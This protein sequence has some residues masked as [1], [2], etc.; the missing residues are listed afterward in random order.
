MKN[1]RVEIVI[2]EEREDDEE[3]WRE[4]NKRSTF[5]LYCPHLQGIN[6]DLRNL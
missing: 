4:W 1:S 5:F 3:G 2:L 6:Y